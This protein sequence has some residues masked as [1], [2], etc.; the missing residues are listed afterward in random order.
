MHDAATSFH[1]G[2]NYVLYAM[3]H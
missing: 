2:I 1:F 3:T